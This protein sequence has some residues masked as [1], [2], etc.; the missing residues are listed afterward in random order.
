M[1]AVTPPR[2]TA[3][4]RFLLGVYALFVVGIVAIG[5]VAF[6]A[7]RAQLYASAEAQVRSVGE[8]RM[9]Q[10]S[11]WLAERRADMAYASRGSVIAEGFD[12]W[13]RGG[14]RDDALAG[15]IRARMWD[16]QA[17]YG[18]AH[19]TL[20]D[21]AGT[22]RLT[23]VPDPH[24]DA[25]AAEARRAMAL[26][27]PLLVDVHEHGGVERLM[28]MVTPVLGGEPGRSRVNGALFAAIPAD[29]Q[30]F[31]LFGRWPTPSAS[32]ETVLAHRQAGGLRTLFASRDSV[33]S[34]TGQPLG[35]ALEAFLAR[36][37][38]DRWHG[39]VPDAVDQRGAPVLAYAAVIPD[40]PW[41]LITKMD[42]AEVDAVVDRNGRTIALVVGLLGLASALAI[43]Q[44]WGV[45]AGRQRTRS[46]ELDLERAERERES[47]QRFRTLADSGQ[48]LVWTAG[49]DRG[50]DYF[51]RVWLDF[52]GRAL[53]QE[54]GH[55]WAQGVHPDD[56]PRCLQTYSDAFERREKFSM[57]YRLRRHDGQYRWVLS[58]GSPRCNAQGEFI[59]YIG[60]CLDITERKQAELLLET[61][62]QLSE[63]SEHL[64]MEG[65]MRAALDLAERHTGSAI[66]FFHF[67]EDDGETLSLQAWSSN[68][69]KNMGQAGGKGTHYPVGQV[70]VW[71]DAVRAR[72]TVIHN[73]Y[74]G[75]AERKGLPEGHA[76]VTRELVVPVQREGRVVAVMGVGNKD[77]DYLA[78]DARI[79]EQF[80]SMAMDLVA[81]KRAEDAA[82]AGEERYRL[83]AEN[84]SD[85][86]W[87]A[88][89]ASL[90]L[91]YVSPSLEGL[92]GYS[93]EAAT[94]RPLA[95][96]LGNGLAELVG[97]R[98]RAC[99]DGTCRD[100]QETAHVEQPH[101]DGH[102]VH[103]EVAL[104]DVR[105]EQGGLRAVL[106]M[107]RDITERQIAQDR[108]N[109]A[110]Y[111]DGL[112]GL[113]NSR[114]LMGEARQAMARL[115]QEPGRLAL[116]L[117]NLDRFAQLNESL[118]RVVGDLVLTEAAGRWKSALPENC[119][120][121][122]LEADQFAVL[123]DRDENEQQALEIASAL[124]RALAEPIRVDDERRVGLTVSVGIAL[125]P[126]DA[127]DEASLL[128][129]AEDAMRD[130]KADKGNQVRFFDRRHAQFTVD[131]FETENALR[132]ALDRNELFL[133]YQ[134]QTEVANGR[135]VGAEALLRWRRDGATVPPGRFIH[136]V[137]GTDLALPVSRW[138]LETACRQ[139]RQWLDRG[140]PL[141]VA[142]NIFS[143]HV[144][145]GH[146]LD[147][148]RRALETAGLPAEWLELEVLES[149]LLHDPD[150]AAKT[151]RALKE[152]GV[153][154]ALDDFGTGYSSLSYLKS[155]PFDVIKIDQAFARNM[156]RDAEDAAIVRS[157][158][159]LGHNLGMRVLAEGIE[160]APQL[161]FLERYGC[162]L[163]Q[164]YL[165]ARPTAPEEVEAMAAAHRDV[166]P[167]EAIDTESRRGILMLE[168]EPLEAEL[169]A[170]DL[171]EAGY[172][173][174]AC[175]GLAGAL[176]ILD[177]E[178]IDI[179]LA[180]HYLRDDATGVQILEKLICLFPDIPRLMMSGTEDKNVVVE[181]VN[182]AGIRAFLPKPIDP[183]TL[184]QVLAEIL[185]QGE[186]AA[187]GDAEQRPACR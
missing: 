106:G 147:D 78:G 27:R 98:V 111:H 157:T 122:R 123:A 112:T 66:G 41:I 80:A 117:L 60:H 52:T 170:L 96:I 151:L 91:T 47:E 48:A 184:R 59:G 146:L 185:H 97:A 187:P 92:L 7:Q 128:H 126:G 24:A 74:P 53:D 163:V 9:N 65:L 159:N 45:Q 164:G 145:S 149:S 175:D 88:D 43:W 94:G 40:T 90:R 95:E 10:L 35:P 36:H 173:V 169:L 158:I 93:A 16:L 38:R 171:E 115:A 113:P 71:A 25:H 121:V 127:R 134:P 85:V 86:I 156:N 148:T 176:D 162:D 69:L 183:A 6:E 11:D 142:V 174:H 21:A 138:V 37:A 136:V 51:N 56:Y 131:W 150:G 116:L 139:A 50:C 152:M 119:H 108:L 32:A 100:S 76:P 1:H 15:R 39:P 161:R 12:A 104:R 124:V 68:T 168:D 172:R 130:A 81:R 29:G 8:L 67:V 4:P 165:L 34:P 54:L 63:L 110:R 99:L 79:V 61:R 129:A 181:A 3:A 18:Y 89:P 64:D 13:L 180:D 178:R 87:L 182:R 179:V 46:L 42:R 160:T 30:F 73:D 26:G 2:P 17:A 57:E 155:Y 22:P 141:R 58:D 82:R 62:L 33:Q 144:A 84:I 114:W 44:W 105:D 153:G 109:H 83:I 20:F 120:L 143:D 19:F 70:G 23:Q 140:H 166:R 49:P 137:E 186:L 14:A 77:S 107:S 75:L 154:L 135:V 103:V 101:R 167:A 28:A 118:G 133:L 125:Y 55:G 31:P 132:R 177:R 5:A 102:L 72:R